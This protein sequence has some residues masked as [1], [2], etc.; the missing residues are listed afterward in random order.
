MDFIGQPLKSLRAGS[1]DGDTDMGPVQHLSFRLLNQILP[2]VKHQ[3]YQLT[4]PAHHSRHT[5]YDTSPR[6]K[7]TADT[8]E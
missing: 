7:T 5:H 4:H 3:Y 1:W 6:P 2:P 8:P